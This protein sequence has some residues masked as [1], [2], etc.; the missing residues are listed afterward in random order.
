MTSFFVLFVSVQKLST[1]YASTLTMK[2]TRSSETLKSASKF[3]GVTSKCELPTSRSHRCE[4]L[5]GDREAL[6]VTAL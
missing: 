2:P 4:K 6:F 3:G 5:V 1:F